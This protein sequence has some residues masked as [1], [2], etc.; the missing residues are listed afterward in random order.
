MALAHW[1]LAELAGWRK[2]PDE[3][4]GTMFGIPSMGP[5]NTE[6]GC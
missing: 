2:V 4:L 5:H 1:L 6:N 3:A